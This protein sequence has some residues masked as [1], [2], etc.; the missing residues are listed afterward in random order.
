MIKLQAELR[1]V[2][3]AANQA[4]LAFRAEL[5]QQR[6][7]MQQLAAENEAHKSQS[8]EF[9]RRLSKALQLS[10]DNE[11]AHVRDTFQNATATVHLWHFRVSV[12]II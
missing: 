7:A 9:E 2:E 11:A 10:A 3:E 5:D 6:E 12:H 8:E 4:R 1:V